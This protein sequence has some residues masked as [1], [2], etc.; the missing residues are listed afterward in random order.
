MPIWVFVLLAPMIIACT[1]AV[2][3][4]VGYFEMSWLDSFLSDTS[5]VATLIGVVFTGFFG[6]AGI[7]YTLSHNARLERERREDALKSELEIQNALR[8]QHARATAAALAGEVENLFRTVKSRMELAIGGVLDEPHLWRSSAVPLPTPVFD[9]LAG[10]LGELG[11]HLAGR[12]SQVFGHYRQLFRHQYEGQKTDFLE[13]DNALI[14]ASLWAP[15]AENIAGLQIELQ[16][17]SRGADSLMDDELEARTSEYLA[18][19][20]PSP[21]GFDTWNQ[22]AEAVRR[23]PE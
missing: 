11:F 19:L 22:V 20:L 21:P 17:R 13:S 3:D 12:T 1:L 16:R 15:L 2:A 14:W 9:A 23:D 10:Q 8:E 4:I 7:M 18:R 5:A 6:F